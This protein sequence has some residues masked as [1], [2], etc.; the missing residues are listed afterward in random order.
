[1][2]WSIIVNVLRN[3][4]SVVLE[5]ASCCKL[6]TFRKLLC[7]HFC[8]KLNNPCSGVA[9][10]E[11]KL[12]N[13]QKITLQEKVQP[14]STLRCFSNI[15]KVKNNC[16]IKFYNWS[17]TLGWQK[18][19]LTLA[20]AL[21]LE[22]KL[23]FDWTFVI[24]NSRM[25]FANYFLKVCNCRETQKYTFVN[26]MQIEA[27]ELKT[28]VLKHLKNVFATVVVWSS[29]F[30]TVGSFSFLSLLYNS[31]SLIAKHKKWHNS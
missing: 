22:F 11:Y 23:S 8:S 24:K 3:P 19:T 26:W 10:L 2:Y 29:W 12:L 7:I 13:H 30:L 25:Y 17:S 6:F 4:T 21:H 18:M 16:I 5:V 15:Q 31:H 9:Y 28:S 14:F 20:N 1:M 27:Y